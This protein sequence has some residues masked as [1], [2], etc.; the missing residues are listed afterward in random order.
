M[1]DQNQTIGEG[2]F[3]PRARIMRTLGDELISSKAALHN[4][5]LTGGI[6]NSPY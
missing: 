2:F 3:R 5:I 1:S 4:H 6:N